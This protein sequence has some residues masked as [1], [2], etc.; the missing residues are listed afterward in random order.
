MRAIAPLTQVQV[1]QTGLHALVLKLVCAEPL[2]AAQRDALVAHLK[3]RFDTIDEV[4]I[5]ELDAIPRGPG[6]KFEAFRC[7]L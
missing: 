7:E 6:L 4:T 1:V 5:Q 3:G 2:G